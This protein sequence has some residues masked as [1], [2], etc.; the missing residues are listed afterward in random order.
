MLRAYEADT[1][2]WVKKHG[3]E[4]QELTAKLQVEHLSQIQD[5]IK[6]LEEMKAGTKVRVI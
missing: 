5:W 2:D 6:T 1:L 4:H 3:E